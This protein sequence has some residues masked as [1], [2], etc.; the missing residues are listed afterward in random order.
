MQYH[1]EF[2]NAYVAALNLKHGGAI[3]PSKVAKQAAESLENL[4]VNPRPMAET[5][6]NFF[7]EKVNP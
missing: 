4:N 1:P 6:K 7:M 2:S 3:I 5:V